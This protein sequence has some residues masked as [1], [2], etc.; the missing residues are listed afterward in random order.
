[1]TSGQPYA[2]EFPSIIPFHTCTV[3]G[4]EPGCLLRELRA[5]GA[6]GQGERPP[7]TRFA[8]HS[9]DVLASGLVIE[10]ATGRSLASYLQEKIWQPLG[11]EHDAYWNLEAA[12]GLAF[13][14]SGISASLRDWARFGLFMLNEGGL[15]DGVSLLPPGWIE[16]ATCAS[17]ASVAAGTPYGFNWWLAK[18]YE[19]SGN[20]GA[21]SARGNAGQ[22]ILVHPAKRMVICKWAAWPTGQTSMGAAELLAEDEA[23]FAS[24]A[25]QV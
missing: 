9:A 13:A 14:N 23:L 1:M 24:I 20:G 21:Y 16:E 17:D 4:D 2:T 22:R 18:D 25:Q 15:P 6:S 10:R 12:G 19:S 3:K 5:L 8:Y 11:M 7:G